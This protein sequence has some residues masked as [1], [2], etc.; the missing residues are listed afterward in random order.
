MRKAQCDVVRLFRKG[1]RVSKEG[2]IDMSAECNRFMP[3]RPWKTKLIFLAIDSNVQG[4][5]DVLRG[6]KMRVQE[7]ADPPYF[8]IVLED[9][10]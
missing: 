6:H 2:L 8:R 9:E 1:K 10:S 7:L 4:V 5:H 3:P